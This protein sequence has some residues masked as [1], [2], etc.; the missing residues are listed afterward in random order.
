MKIL[1]KNGDINIGFYYFTL[2]SWDAAAQ[3]CSWNKL[4]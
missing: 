2:R 4:L 3:V 1:N